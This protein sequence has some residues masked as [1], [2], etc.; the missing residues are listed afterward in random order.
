MVG[1]TQKIGHDQFPAYYDQVIGD[2]IVFAPRTDSKTA[3]S[4]S[5]ANPED[6]ARVLWS[7]IQNTSSVVVLEDFIRHHGATLFG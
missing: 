2:D 7:T 6:P 4:E 5:G 3:G 1:L